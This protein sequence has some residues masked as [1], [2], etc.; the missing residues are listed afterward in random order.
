MPF[1]YKH[2]FLNGTWFIFIRFDCRTDE[3]NYRER[4]WETWYNLKF[5]FCAFILYSVPD[6]QI[7]TN[8]G[9][10]GNLLTLLER[11]FPN[12]RLIGPNQM[13]RRGW[14]DER[15]LLTEGGIP[16]ES[17]KLEGKER[18][19]NSA[20]TP[21]ASS[22]WAWEYSAESRLNSKRIQ[23]C[24]QLTADFFHHGSVWRTRS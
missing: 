23:L 17:G 9:L 7:T 16:W 19:S 15:V 5:V 8:T 11:L 24:Q 1:E 20:T 22:D 18:N 10:N 21:C 6:H 14:L 3:L 13:Q 2:H 4:C 12:S